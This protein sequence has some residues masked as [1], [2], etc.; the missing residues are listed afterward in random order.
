MFD[1][2]VFDNLK[3]VIEGAFY[4]LDLGGQYRVYDRHDMA[5]LATLKR[6]YQISLR[7]CHHH[8]KLH[9]ATFQLEMDISNLSAE[10]LNI[11]G[12]KPGCTVN[13]SFSLEA[14]DI[15]KC[16]EI[17]MIMNEIWGTDRQI[18]QIVSFKYPEQSTP[19]YHVDINISFNRVITEEQLDDMIEMIDYITRTLDHLNQ[20]V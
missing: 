8:K 7:N 18:E 5:D 12:T 1:P 17:E 15:K 16:S 19:L 6:I 10:L 20:I 2:T 4:D 11:K 9:G 14:N 13:I 3:V